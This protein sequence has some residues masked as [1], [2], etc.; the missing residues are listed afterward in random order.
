MSYLIFIG[1][2]L[3]LLEICWYLHILNVIYSMIIDN[4]AI[5]ISDLLIETLGFLILFLLDN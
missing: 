1:G 2:F 5:N 4:T 3:L